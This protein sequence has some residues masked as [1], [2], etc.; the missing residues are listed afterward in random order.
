MNSSLAL[1]SITASSLSILSAVSQTTSAPPFAPSSLNPART[2]LD[3]RANIATL[4]ATLDHIHTLSTARRKAVPVGGGAEGD[5]E[6]KD[7]RE[8]RLME[9]V[10]E[11]RGLVEQAREKGEIQR[12]VGEALESSWLVGEAL[13]TAPEG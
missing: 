10:D 6:D 1:E 11:L 3:L 8:A 5:S 9:R 7:V 12:R 13:K 4:A 2:L